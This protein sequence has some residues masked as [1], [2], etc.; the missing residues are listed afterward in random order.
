MAAA[1]PWVTGGLSLASS[2][3][4]SRAES[5]NYESQAVAQEIAA[6]EDRR[7]GSEQ[8][9]LI[10]AQSDEVTGSTVSKAAG[11][12]VVVSTGSVLDVIAENAYNIEMDALATEESAERAATA[13]E[14]EAANLRASKPSGISTL[15]SAT[16]SAVSGYASGL[17]LLG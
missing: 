4:Q 9:A 10:R 15:L 5:A 8:S 7:V 12:G 16:G 6:D 2:L 13:K 3:S 11:S 14:I 17:S 1:I